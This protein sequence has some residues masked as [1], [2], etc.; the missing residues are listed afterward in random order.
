MNKNSCHW[1][2]LLFFLWH[3]ITSKEQIKL[4]IFDEGTE[5]FLLNSNGLCINCLWHFNVQ[6]IFRHLYTCTTCHRSKVW[7]EYAKRHALL[8]EPAARQ[9]VSYYTCFTVHDF[10][11]PGR[12]RLTKTAVPS[13]RPQEHWQSVIC[14][15][16]ALFTS[17]CMQNIQVE[18]LG[19]HATLLLLLRKLWHYSYF[20]LASVVWS[21]LGDCVMFAHLHHN[22]VCSLSL[23]IIGLKL[24]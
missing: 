20:Y 14:R 18:Q 23:S 4:Y 11:D 15:G 16:N 5:A 9:Y 8:D 3:P 13:V 19:L 2:F 1:K 21:R 24:P 7:V 6:V 12:T 22:I 10:M 17:R